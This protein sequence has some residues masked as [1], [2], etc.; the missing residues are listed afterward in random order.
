M[1]SKWKK[2]LKHTVYSRQ[3]A[4]NRLLA[5]RT[6]A[7][8]ILRVDDRSIPPPDAEIRG[9]VVVRNESLRLPFMLKYY[10]ALGVDRIFVLDNDS[11][12]NSQS[13]VM[14]FANTHLLFTD[15]TYDHQA[16]WIDFLLRRYGT[17]CWCLVVDAD[18][19]FIYP[20]VENKSLRDFCSSLDQRSFNALDCMLLDM[21]PDKPL[22]EIKYQ[23]GTDPLVTAPFFDPLSSNDGL[24]IRDYLH[25]QNLF[26][27]GPSRFTGGVRK[28]IFDADCCI[29]KF[30]LLRFNHSMFLSPGTHFVE[31]ARISPMRGA[32]LHFKFLN[33]F[34]QSVTHEVVRGQRSFGNNREYL[35]YLTTLRRFPD[36]TLHTEGSVRYYN[37]YQLVDLG[38][39]KRC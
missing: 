1:F 38:I 9:F 12:D 34:A 21:Y 35:S 17:G 28:R 4:I 33:D 26:Y 27:E 18:E 29:S 15:D 23:P 16:Y 2:A 31:G 24:I 14:S 30:P 6:A 36:L 13:I 10:F 11:T 39:M 19:R 32:L 37:S 5:R 20:D 8:K 25:D 3:F 22:N 7:Q